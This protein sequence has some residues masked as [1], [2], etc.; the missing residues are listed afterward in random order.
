MNEKPLI[1]NTILKIIIV[2]IVIATIPPV[3]GI[4]YEFFTHEPYEPEPTQEVTTRTYTTEAVTT[5]SATT[6]TT[7]PCIEVVTTTEPVTIIDTTEPT[8][9][10]ITTE[11]V[12]ERE[13]WVSFGEYTIT[14]YCPCTKCCGIWSA[15]H[16]RRIGTDYIQKTAS[17]TIPTDGRTAGADTNILPFGTVVMI[18]GHEYIIEDTGNAAWG[19]KLID[20]YFDTHEEAIIFGKRTVEI[21]I[22]QE[23][24]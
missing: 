6:A 22:K 14:A 1:I 24:N 13:E 21:F 10:Y 17:G 7:E 18:D 12:T 19:K 11:S 3:I 16:P 8:T 2:L 4:T 23:V 20:V 15:A 5:M 9:E